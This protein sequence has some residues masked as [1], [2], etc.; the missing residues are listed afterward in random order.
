MAKKLTDILI[1][2]VAI[3]CIAAAAAHAGPKHKWDFDEEFMQYEFSW[4][5]IVAA[6]L[7]AYITKER[8]LYY[9]SVK[10][11]TKPAVDLLW[12]MRDKLT[13][14]TSAI[15]LLPRYYRFNQRE[16][17]YYM[18]IEI[19]FD[20][21]TNTACGKRTN[22]KGK[23]KKRTVQVEEL[24]DPISSILFL[25]RQPLWPDDVYRLRVFDGRKLY[26]LRYEVVGRKRIRTYRGKLWTRKVIP[27]LEK[28]SEKPEEVEE[29][30]SEVFMYLTEDDP[31]EIVLIES[32]VFIGK[33]KA[34]LVRRSGGKLIKPKQKSDEDEGK[35]AP[36]SEDRSE[37]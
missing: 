9:V 25:R 20:P 26:V 14:T 21:E 8:D 3:A 18:D 30:V 12:K 34:K 33:V 4:S 16:G 35:N 2:A 37:D 17:R 7:N 23:V 31:H 10:A 1:A 13:L 15:D 22:K 36:H 24:Y 6:E 32:D 28:A 19:K 29:R 27:S 5:G 11:R